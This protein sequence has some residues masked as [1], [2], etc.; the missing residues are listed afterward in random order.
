MRTHKE[1]QASD[2]LSSVSDTPTGSVSESSPQQTPGVY[3]R[4][5]CVC[6]SNWA[7]AVRA[8]YGEWPGSWEAV[9]LDHHSP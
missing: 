5:A 4:S 1:L 8:G 2:W 3:L 7:E 9:Y 6:A